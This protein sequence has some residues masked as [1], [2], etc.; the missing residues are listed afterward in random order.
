MREQHQAVVEMP[1][2]H[3]NL[4]SLPAI[5]SALLCDHTVTTPTQTCSDGTEGIDGNGVVCCPTD[6]GQCGGA[7]C[8][9][10]GAAAGLDGSDCC[11]GTIRKAGVYCDDTDKAPC[12]IGR[13]PDPGEPLTPW[14]VQIDTIR[15]LTSELRVS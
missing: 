9:T 6:C 2:A 15:S 14:C 7:G 11:G 1:H 5:I 12:I 4:Q 10:A 13:A 3:S 8:T